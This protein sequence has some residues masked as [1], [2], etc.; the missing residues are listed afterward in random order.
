MQVV[1]DE[2]HGCAAVTCHVQEQEQKVPCMRVHGSLRAPISSLVLGAL[3]NRFS[4]GLGHSSSSSSSFFSLFNISLPLVSLV[5]SG[6][7]ATLH[8]YMRD[9]YMSTHMV[10]YLCPRDVVMVDC[11]VPYAPTTP[12]I[13]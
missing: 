6:T 1:G 5:S 11:W 12:L 7:D 9:S 10:S 2:A 13:V 4:Q 3:A 8:T